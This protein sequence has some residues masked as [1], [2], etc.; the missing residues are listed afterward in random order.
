MRVVFSRVDILSALNKIQGI[1][2]QKPQIPILSNVLLLAIGNEFI[3]TATDLALSMKITVPAK[4][5]EEGAIVLSAKKLLLLIK[6]L[7]APD[8]EIATSPFHI[9]MIY[10]GSS[11]FKIPGIN[12]A[13]FP[14]VPNITEGTEVT[15]PTALLREMLSKTSF[16]AGRDET[17][18]IF[19]SIHLQREPGLTLFTGA[20]GKRVARSSTDLPLPEEW[21]GSYVLPI[22]TAEEM[23]KLLDTEEET[24]S[25]QFPERKLS[26]RAGPVTLVS[27][28]LSG[29]YPDISRII[30]EKQPSSIDL[31]R[32][33]L[34]SLLR[35]IALFTSEERSSVRFTFTPGELHLSITGTDSGEGHVHMPINYRG[36]R[37]DI[38]FNASFFLDILR[39]SKDE[40]VQLSI[41]DGYNPGL[42]TDSSSS[43]F[44]LMPM[45]LEN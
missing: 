12:P 36:E 13:D 31:H 10:S 20:D 26:L 22:K 5:L 41:K 32:E 43:F 34:I 23:I 16:S 11:Q 14:E 28:L 30:P 9:A 27:Q 45:R 15:F 3:I 2:P 35:Q 33:E 18:P 38:A 1:I 37:M 6:E 29:Q 4:V 40:T 25:L 7:T 17:R 8:V 44:V 24:V 39:H 42:I 19:S 21:Q